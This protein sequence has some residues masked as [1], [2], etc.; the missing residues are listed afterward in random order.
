VDEEQGIYRG[1]VTTMVGVLAD[2]NVNVKTILA[3]IKG[4]E[5]DGEEEEE[6]RPS[7]S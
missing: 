4:E 3:Y 6:D 5:D 2:I 7:D 1:E